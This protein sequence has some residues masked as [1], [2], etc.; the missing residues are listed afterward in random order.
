MSF[1]H[2]CIIANYNI[3]HNHVI[4]KWS[5]HIYSLCHNL[6]RLTLVMHCT[7]RVTIAFITFLRKHQKHL[8]LKLHVHQIH[9][10]KRYICKSIDSFF[11]LKTRF[12]TQIRLFVACKLWNPFAGESIFLS[13]FDWLF[14][15][16]YTLF[17]VHTNCSD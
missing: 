10:Q 12:Y 7:V 3:S 1:R 2:G 4:C 6:S 15:G 17:T 5:Q 9:H 14:N 8:S 11:K 13:S 16:K